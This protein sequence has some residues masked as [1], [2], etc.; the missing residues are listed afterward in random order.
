MENRKQMV[1]RLNQDRTNRLLRR[2][3]AS[4]MHALVMR[5]LTEKFK[6]GLISIEQYEE[7]QNDE[8]IRYRNRIVELNK[9]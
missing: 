5:Q 9:S 6:A 8:L 2:T 4:E 3:H 1:D 7:E